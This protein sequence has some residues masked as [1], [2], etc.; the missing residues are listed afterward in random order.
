MGFNHDDVMNYIEALVKKYKDNEYDLM[1]RIENLNIDLREARERADE[2]KDKL[3]DASESKT[4]EMILV[5]LN[6]PTA[7]AI[8][9]TRKGRKIK[10]GAIRRGGAER[11]RGQSADHIGQGRIDAKDR[12]IAPRELN[13]PGGEPTVL[14]IGVGIAPERD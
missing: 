4:E 14:V 1:A 5:M 6:K 11:S 10:R 9:G 3:A 12:E 13:E 7:G 2:R 8:F